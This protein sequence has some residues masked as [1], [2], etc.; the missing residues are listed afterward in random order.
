M[1]DGGVKV[2]KEVSY[3]GWFIK[4][5]LKLDEVRISCWKFKGPT[6]KQE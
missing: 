3:R 6:I 4:I 2:K 1:Q 5:P